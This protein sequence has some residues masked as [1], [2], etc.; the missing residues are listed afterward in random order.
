MHKLIS[1]LSVAFLGFIAWIIYL[2]NTAQNSVFFEF[3]ASIPNGDKLGHFCLFGLLTLG[4]NFAFKLK[5]ITLM[6]SNIYIGSVVVFVL[7]LV[8]ELSQ[9]FIPN[10]TLD[11]TD[12]LADF[13]GIITFSL[14]TKF[15]EKHT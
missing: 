3:V 6:S 12:L 2:A 13:V 7:V 1:I 9:Y 8:E 11:A 14:I 10:R 5:C 15:I 4:A